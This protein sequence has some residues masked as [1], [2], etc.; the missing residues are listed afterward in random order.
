KLYTSLILS[1]MFAEGITL[2]N[3]H[4]AQLTLFLPYSCG[5]FV[6]PK[7]HNSFGIKQIRTLWPKH[8]GW[9]VSRKICPTE[10]ATYKLF[11]ADLFAHQLPHRPFARPLFSWCYESLFPQPICFQNHLRSP[12]VLGEDLFGAR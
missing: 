1:V 8:P 7:K 10:S 11:L 3:A 6:A 12:L 4:P 5:L 9:G 2:S